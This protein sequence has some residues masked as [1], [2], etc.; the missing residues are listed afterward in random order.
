[1]AS[2]KTTTTGNE[3]PLERQRALTGVV[4]ALWIVGVRL[5]QE[6][7]LVLGAPICLFSTICI[8]V[9]YWSELKAIRHQPIRVWA[10]VG[11]ILIAIVILV[12]GYLAIPVAGHVPAMPLPQAAGSNAPT[13][14]SPK[15]AA[16][17][18]TT[19]GPQ[20]PVIQDTKG[21]VRIDFNAQPSPK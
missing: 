21:D 13:I 20:S 17:S 15:S 19:T 2:T 12:P 3:P 16:S 5:I 10:W 9:L 7:S 1:M 14:T 8:V 18:V 6:T 4:L 11:L